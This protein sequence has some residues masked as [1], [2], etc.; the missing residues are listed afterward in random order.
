MHSYKAGNLLAK[1]MTDAEAQ[2]YAETNSINIE[3]SADAQLVGESSAAALHDEDADGEVEKE[4]TPPP[5]KTP[6]VK[7]KGGR[8]TKAKATETPAVVEEAI[9][10]T[11][12]PV[13]ASIVPPPSA[14]V[15]EKEKSPDKKRKRASK[16]S[17]GA[18]EVQAT[19]AVEKEELAVET[20]KTASKPR[21]KKAKN[22]A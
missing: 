1:D 7:A 11:P 21:K 4:P 3:N 10:P 6:S 8:K 20:P 16:K 14:K 15:V 9:V 19:P 12:A 5:Q 22:D 2:L 13:A 18:E 17:V